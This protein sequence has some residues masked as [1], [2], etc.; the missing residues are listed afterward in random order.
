MFVNLGH[1]WTQFY[2]SRPLASLRKQSNQQNTS[3][4]NSGYYC[5][6]HVS[7]MVLTVNS[8]KPRTRVSSHNTQVV[9]VF[10]DSFW[11]LISTCSLSERAAR[12]QNWP[13]L[14]YLCS[15]EDLCVQR[16]ARGAVR[17]G[18]FSEDGANR[19]KDCVI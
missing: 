2:T 5:A 6:S 17:L 4:Q 16:V 14:S 7:L 1:T 10:E 12:V 19:R 8:L 3:S 9:A 13:I 11:I 15:A 18:L